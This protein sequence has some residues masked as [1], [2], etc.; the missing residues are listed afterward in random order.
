MAALDTRK[1]SGSSV[2][3]TVISE[4]VKGHFN[5]TVISKLKKAGI[6]VHDITFVPDENGDFTKG[7]TAYLLN[8][9]GTGRLRDWKGVMAI[10]AEL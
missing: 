8:D 9:N 4:M 2:L 1:L 5:R 10:F 7:Q 3:R 6:T